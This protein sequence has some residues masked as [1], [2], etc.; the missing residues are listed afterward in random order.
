MTLR[1]IITVDGGSAEYWRRRRLAF[2]L[3][4]DAELAAR[5]LE[6]APMYIR[7]R[8]DDDYGD[9]EPVENLGP[10]DDMED[11]IRAIEANETA[12]SILVAQRRTQ[13]GNYQ[14]GAVIRE[15]A[16]LDDGG[17][18]EDPE[19]DYERLYGSDW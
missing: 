2:G 10:H 1:T 3:I 19:G 12:V 4:R 7:G 16:L 8:W 9:Y 5:R 13:I 18:D 17:S 14:I 15:L 6:T 11:A